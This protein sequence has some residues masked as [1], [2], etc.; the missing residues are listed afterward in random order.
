MQSWLGDAHR[1][2]KQEGEDIGDKMHHAFENAIERGS[3]A[4]LLIGSDCPEL[5]TEILTKAFNALK[6]KDLVLGPAM[7]G[8]YYL[9]GLK[10]PCPELF[11]DISWS[12]DEVLRETLTKADQ[13]GMSVYQ[14]PTLSD[15]DTAGHLGCRI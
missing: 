2:Y 8:G 13:L 1:Y 15:I 4:C 7:D 11:S 12:T 10:K 3:D 9:M 6:D 5:S 14:L